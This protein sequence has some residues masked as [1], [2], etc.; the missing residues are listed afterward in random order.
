M[1]KIKKD[2]RDGTM[3]KSRKRAAQYFVVT[4]L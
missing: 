3:K 4:I 1:G 2:E